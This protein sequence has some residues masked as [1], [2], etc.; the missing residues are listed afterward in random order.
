[1]AKDYSDFVTLAKRLIAEYGREFVLKTYSN[2]GTSF[3]PT[4]TEEADITL[5]GVFTKISFENINEN[6]IK[7]GDKMLLVDSTETISEKQK[8]FDD[9]T[10]YEIV[11]VEEIK[12]G[13]TLIMS[14]LLV[15]S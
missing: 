14:K 10:L 2:T 1:M 6:L 11:A 3:D 7:K 12:P 9:S 5:D 4:V 15:R 13:S 8:V